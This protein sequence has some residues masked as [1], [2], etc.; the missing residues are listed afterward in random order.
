MNIFDWRLWA[1]YIAIS[2]VLLTLVF[3]LTM[4]FD[5]AKNRKI[6]NLQ[7][8]VET[9]RESIQAI[10]ASNHDV[11]NDLIKKG[12]LDPKAYE[13]YLKTAVSPPPPTTAANA[14]SQ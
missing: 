7:T 11:I 12:Q 6:E 3:V 5:A 10:A 2:A 14:P 4:G 8:Q 9:L 13:K 1:A